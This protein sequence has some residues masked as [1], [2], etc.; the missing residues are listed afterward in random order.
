VALGV[1]ALSSAVRAASFMVPGSLGIQE[2]GNVFI[3]G[4]FGLPPDAAMAF[5]LLRRIREWGWAAAG[6]L[7]VRRLS[8]EQRLSL[9]AA[10]A[11]G[12]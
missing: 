8:P 6:L 12:R 2:G 7:L 3:F 11:G 9:A 5:S 10:R 1:V 4:S